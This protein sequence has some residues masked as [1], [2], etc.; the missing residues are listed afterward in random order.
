MKLGLLVWAT[1]ALA[2]P[3]KP[4]RPA[5]TQGYNVPGSLSTLPGT[6]STSRVNGEPDSTKTDTFTEAISTGSGVGEQPTSSPFVLLPSTGQPDNRET[7]GVPGTQEPGNTETGSI[8]TET[9]GVPISNTAVTQP[10]GTGTETQGQGTQ[11]A[12]TQTG[13]VP[14]T[15]PSGSVH[16][17][18]GTIGDQTSVEAPSGTQTGDLTT[19]VPSG[20]VPSSS[21][22]TGVPGTQTGDVPGTIGDET[23]VGAPTGSQTADIPGTV[24]DETSVSTPFG[25]QTGDIP[26]NVP[27][28][29]QTADVPGTT[30]DETSFVNEPSGPQSQGTEGAPTGT[31]EV[32]GTS[33]SDNTGAT[34][35]P[36]ADSTETASGGVPSEV[37]SGDV[38][39]SAPVSQTGS[40]T[41]LTGG[42]IPTGIETGSPIDGTS[43][44]AE[45]ANTEAGSATEVSG[46]PTGTTSGG[47][48]TDSNPSNTPGNSQPAE[49]QS[50]SGSDA[51]T[52]TNATGEPQITG[53]ATSDITNIGSVPASETT[54]PDAGVTDSVPISTGVTDLPASTEAPSV[55]S[56]HSGSS[57]PIVTQVPDGWAPTCVSGHTEWTA[58]TW[59]TTTMEGSTTP[60]VVPVLVDSKDCDDDGSGLILFGFPPVIGTI[61]KLPKAPKFSLPCIPPGC[62]SPPTTEPA[63]AGDGDDGEDEPSKSDR[64][65]VTCTD[66]S[67]VSNC[68]VQCTTRTGV[69]IAA[70]PECTTTCSKTAT[71]CSVTG[72]TTTTEVDACKETSDAWDPDGDC[73]CANFPD[74]GLPDANLPD[75]GSSDPE[76]E[77][78]SAFTENTGASGLQAR[79]AGPDVNLEKKVGFCDDT[80]LKRTFNFPSYPQGGDIIKVEGELKKRPKE[81]SHYRDVKRWYYMGTDTDGR[82]TLMG[83]KNDAATL[84]LLEKA[85]A[86]TDHVFEKSFLREFWKQITKDGAQPADIYLQ[87]EPQ[88]TVKI[89]SCDDLFNYGGGAGMDL[90][91]DVYLE[92]PGATFF[93]FDAIKPTNSKLLGDMAG[94]DKWGL[95]TSPSDLNR[96]IREEIRPVNPPQSDMMT[97]LG[98]VETYLKWI[99]QIKIGTQVASHPDL[100]AIMIRQNSRIYKALQKMDKHAKCKNDAATISGKWSF[101]DRYKELMLERFDGSVTG[102]SINPQISAAYTRLFGL[103]QNGINDARAK[104]LQVPAATQPAAMAKFCRV[105]DH[106]NLVVKEFGASQQTFKPP[107]IS[108]PAWEW[109]TLS[110]RDGEGS[111]KIDLPT[112]SSE[113]TT[114]STVFTSSKSE[115]E[116]TT[117]SAP[118][119]TRSISLCTSDKDC[120]SMDC[121]EDQR[122][123]CGNTVQPLPGLPQLPKTCTCVAETT[124]TAEGASTTAEE[125]QAPSIGLMT[126]KTKEDCYD[127]KCDEEGA[128][129]VCGAG[130]PIIGGIP[131]FCHCVKPATTTESTP[132]KTEDPG[133]DGP[134]K[135]CAT[136]SDC[137]DW[138]GD[139]DD[140]EKFC[141]AA[142]AT[143]I[144]GVPTFTKS[145]CKCE[146]REKEKEDPDFNAK[147]PEMEC[148]TH[149]DCS[150]WKGKCN[151]GKKFCNAAGAT[152]INGVPTFTK[153]ICGC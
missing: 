100:Q 130:V 29:T 139:C 134:E 103:V 94:M 11:P 74:S 121:K 89:I 79:W 131:Q 137:V 125:T 129:P 90:V 126:C 75:S 59:I 61:F 127:F 85:Q 34:T 25:T 118:T 55:T 132:E 39:G 73:G 87:P 115:E 152:S 35:L 32:T 70:T 67:T 10:L 141:N 51:E 150:E 91:N 116:S 24:G 68:L 93:K 119:A 144:N 46:V 120:E 109:P 22:T 82:P 128:R 52:E 140:D 63:G 114:F 36:G 20:S 133:A 135:K 48:E 6:G 123:V 88:Q 44:G 136:H 108:T 72:T 38:S 31:S 1:G 83:P 149:D 57:T 143:T 138:D 33:P 9:G 98:N 97:F 99:E 2:G 65:S 47:A 30:G 117:D 13:D 41:D 84:K 3:C 19:I 53:S 5:T 122:A 66:A 64:S 16:S 104:M 43:T 113:A 60:T 96:R 12:G 7:G 71:G 153:S 148:A 69:N 151:D 106:W 23:S 124:T 54:K 105:R 17:G 49:S 50:P 81:Y 27:S 26:G 111:C 21:Q 142:G 86:T 45:P 4:S 42:P 101:A 58:N 92:Y 14:G 18:S 147:L 40:N 8:G 80:T 78:R 15:G 146:R 102:F 77:S 110:K 62:T 56:A 37:P 112:T 95:A 107:K 28:G 145:I 76:L